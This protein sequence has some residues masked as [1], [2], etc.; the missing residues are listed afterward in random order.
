MKEK[1]DRLEIALEY[2]QKSITQHYHDPSKAD[3]VITRNKIVKGPGGNSEEIDLYV[4]ISYSEDHK[5]IFIYECKNWDKQKLD[6][7]LPTIVDNKVKI[8]NAQLGFILGKTVTTGFTKK[9]TEFPRLKYLQVDSSAAAIADLEEFGLSMRRLTDARLEVVL[10]D[11]YIENCR[12][13]SP[14]S[15]D[16]MVIHI[17][18]KQMAVTDFLETHIEFVAKRSETEEQLNTIK[19]EGTNALSFSFTYTFKEAD[20]HCQGNKYYSMKI[21]YTMEAYYS[22]AKIV[23]HFDIER[24]GKYL[25]YELHDEFGNKTLVNLTAPKY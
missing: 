16:D 5:V 21:V 3:M 10:Y 17:Y 15:V 22:E 23:Y 8:C 4:E 25:R 12:I 2:L 9:L 24:N 19:T 7:N 1:G 13:M 20:I 11:D 6:K 14:I 18:G